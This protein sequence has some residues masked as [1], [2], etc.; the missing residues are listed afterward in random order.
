MGLFEN[1]TPKT[2]KLHPKNH[3]PK[4]PYPYKCP[5]WAFYENRT[6]FAQT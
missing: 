1:R 2:L 6:F 3:T 4:K 5:K